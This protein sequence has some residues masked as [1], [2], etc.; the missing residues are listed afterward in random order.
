MNIKNLG[1]GELGL[2][3]TSKVFRNLP[4]ER[5]IEEGLINDETKMAMNG[6]VMVDTGKYTGRSPKDKY[7]VVEDSSKDKLWWGEVNSKT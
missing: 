6:A 7:F 1:L 2:E 5:I 4:I 3:L